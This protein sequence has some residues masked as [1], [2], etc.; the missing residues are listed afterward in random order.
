[1]IHEIAIDLYTNKKPE[2]NNFFFSFYNDVA[3]NMFGV[4]ASFSGSVSERE[5]QQYFNS[6]L[7]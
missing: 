6:H 4:E 7:R 5:N 2:E 1:L 3:K